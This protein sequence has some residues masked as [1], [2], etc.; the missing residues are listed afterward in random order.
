M[1]LEFDVVDLPDTSH[2]EEGDTAPEFTRPLVG[3]GYWEDISLSEIAEDGFVLLVFTPM[4]GSFPSTYIWQ[5]VRDRGWGS[6]EEVEVV[7]VTVSTPYSHKDLIRDLDL[8]VRLYS[9]PGN[10]VAELYGVEH[11]LDDMEGVSEPRPAVYLLDPDLAVEYCWVA[12]EWPDFPPYDEV[13]REL[14]S[15]SRSSRVSE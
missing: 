10:D 12:G 13:E 14:E 7:G 9:D 3:T 1:D 15:L 6:I 8:N 4:N 5:E 2:V 11:S